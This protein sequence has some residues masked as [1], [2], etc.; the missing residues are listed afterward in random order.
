M[1]KPLSRVL[2]AEDRRQVIGM[3]GGMS[4]LQETAYNDDLKI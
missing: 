1:L 2:E 4:L 3:L